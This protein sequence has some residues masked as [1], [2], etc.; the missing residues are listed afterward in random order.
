MLPHTT[1]KLKIFLS[2]F[3]SGDQHLKLTRIMFQ[4]IVSAID[5]N[6]VKLSSCQRIILLS[7]NNET[8]LIDFQHYSIRLQ[9]IGLAMVQK[10]KLMKNRQLSLASELDRVNR[11]S[12][13]SAVRLQEIGP[14]M[15]LH[16]VKV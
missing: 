13:Q 14:R 6:T 12:T 5:I 2:G 16:L 11:A 8:N 9:L 10:V 7:Y 3:G 15:T 1:L 4:N